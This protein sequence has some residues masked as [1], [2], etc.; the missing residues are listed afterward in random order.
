MGEP[1]GRWLDTVIA[2][3]TV[4]GTVEWLPARRGGIP[5]RVATMN[6]REF[7]V[8][9]AVRRGGMQQ[10][11]VRITGFVWF[12]AAFLAGSPAAQLHVKESAIGAFRTLKQAKA[13]VS[14]ARR[15]LD[16]HLRRCAA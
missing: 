1:L 7:A 15:L 13:A 16:D 4:P 11:N 3:N 14:E 5:A 9:R 10:W 12:Q 2:A 6:G 8:A